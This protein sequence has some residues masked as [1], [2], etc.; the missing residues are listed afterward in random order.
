V[1]VGDSTA[2]TNGDGLQRWGASTG[3]LE[4]ATV[5][6]SGCATLTGERFR[7]R[8][9]YEF[10]PHGCDQLFAT[11]AATAKSIHA[12]AIVVFIGSSQLADWRYAD[13]DGWHHLGEAVI[14]SRYVV[15]LD[16]ALGTLA[17]AGV[18]ILWADTPTPAWDHDVFGQQLGGGD[19]PGQGPVALNNAERAAALN[20][21]DRQRIPTNP[22]ATVWP[23]TAELAGPGGAIS[24]DVRPDGLHVSP[25]A[26]AAIADRSLFDTMGRAYRSVL[27]RSAAGAAAPRDQAWSRG[28]GASS[29]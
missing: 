29:R 22:L 27:D 5:S 14:D 3:R 25:E 8:E 24:T 19:L 23:Y 13:L 1:V 11:A 18:P 12:D 17:T 21:T 16:Q 4:V 10:V 6:G 9:G 20:A 2:G 26:M 15:A 28:S 7:V